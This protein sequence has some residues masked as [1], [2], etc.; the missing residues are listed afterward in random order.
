MWYCSNSK[1]WFVDLRMT[2]EIL[3][4][5]NFINNTI[6]VSNKYIKVLWR[7]ALFL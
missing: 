5:C 1:Q 4:F 3:V 2:Y 7:E 6:N